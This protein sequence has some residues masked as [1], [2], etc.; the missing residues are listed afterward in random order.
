M[1]KPRPTKPQLKIDC[2]TEL[3]LVRMIPTLEELAL[4]PPRKNVIISAD[5]MMLSDIYYY[6]ICL[7]NRCTSNE[8]RDIRERLGRYK[9][10]LE[11]YRKELGKDSFINEWFFET[12]QDQL[13]IRSIL[14]IHPDSPGMEPRYEYF[15]KRFSKE[16]KK[17]ISKAE[18]H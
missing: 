10:D 15:E 17:Y 16:I 7:C 4:K 5:K 12:L 8:A 6:F 3:K 11:R 13:V 1:A 9:K 18:R 2:D 14:D